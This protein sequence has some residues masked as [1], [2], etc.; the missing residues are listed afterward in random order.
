MPKYGKLFAS[1]IICEGAGFIGSF[2]TIPAI[3]IWYA[4]L[5]KPSFAPPNFIFGPVWTVL[6]LLMGI[7]LYLVWEKKDKR[8]VIRGKG[9][10]FFALQLGLNVLWSAMF[11][12]QKSPAL[13]LLVIV[14]LWVAIFQ[15]IK[16]FGKINTAA[17]YLLYPYLLWVSFAAV[18]N[19]MIWQL[20]R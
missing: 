15:T 6:Y 7:S 18:L 12:G 19:F 17:S 3:S 16:F 20:N 14:L 9:L 5:V 8:R 11:F 10:Q 13:G 2:F 1:I 4:T